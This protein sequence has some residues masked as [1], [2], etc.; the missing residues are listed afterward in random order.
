MIKSKDSAQLSLIPALIRQ[1]VYSDQEKEFILNNLNKTNKELAAVLRRSEGSIRKYLNKEQVR[2]SDEQIQQIRD[3]VAANQS[4]EN[5]PNFKG[6][7][8]QDNYYYKKRMN[9]KY[10]EK[11][12]ARDKVYRAIKSGKLER[13]VCEIC[14]DPKTQAHHYKGYDHPL[15][16]KWLC[17]KHHNELEKQKKAS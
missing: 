9:K 13:L 11:K 17:R 3:R 2:R 7:R 12:I 15:D 14:G 10:P 1:S 6:F 8:S 16:V 5:N 4:G